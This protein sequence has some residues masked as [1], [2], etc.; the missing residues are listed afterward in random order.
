MVCL[1]PDAATTPAMLADTLDWVP[2]SVPG[3]A[4]SALRAAGRWDGVAPLPLDDRDVWYRGTVE[5][6]GLV[7]LR[8]EGLA[9]RATLWLGEEEILRSESMFVPEERDAQLVPGMRIAIRFASILKAIEG[10]R[11]RPRWRPRLI[12]PPQLRRI[13]TTLLGHMPGWCPAIHTVGPWGA[14]TATPL[15]RTPRLLASRLDARLDADGCGTLTAQIRLS[16]APTAPP[17]L[18]LDGEEAVFEETD[19]TWIA[20]LALAAPRPWWP[21]T[22]GEPVLYEAALGMDGARYSLGRVGFRRLALDRGAD[23]RDFRLVVNGVPLFCRGAN[24]VGADIAAVAQASDAMDAALAH[25]VGAHCNMLRVPGIATYESGAFYRA[26]DRLGILVWQDCAFANFDY[27][28]DDAFLGLACAEVEAFLDRTAASP[29]LAVLCGGSEIAQQAAM[30]GA[31]EAQRTHPLFDTVIPD[32]VRRLRPDIV[33]AP[34]SPFGAGLPFLPGDGVSHYYGVGAYQRALAD[35]RT[36]Q[37]RFASE[38]LAFSIP[39]DDETIAVTLGCRQTHD[40]RWKAGVPRDPGTPWD[41]EDVRDFYLRSQTGLDPAR[42]RYEDPDAYLDRSRAMLA[43]LYEGVI[44]EWRRPGSTNAGALVWLFQDVR[45]GAGWGLLDSEGRPKSSWYGLRRACAPI[46]LSMTDEGLNG[47]FLHL[48][49]DTAESIEATLSFRALYQ[50]HVPVAQATRDIVLPPRSAQTIRSADLLTRFFDVTYAYRF[51]PAAH[52]VS[53]AT[54]FGRH[55]TALSEAIHLVPGRILSPV[56][57]DFEVEPYRSPSGW[58]LRLRANRFAQSIRIHDRALRAEDAWFS[59][60]PDRD[61]HVALAGDESHAPKGEI[62][63]LNAL[64]PWSY[65]A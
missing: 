58:M 19:G 54:L 33:H 65:A 12:A 4:A 41:F 2:A 13:R 48:I 60:A 57:I 44:D 43:D 10:V 17:R 30:L 36:A 49:N 24:W 6:E 7:R 1:P 3:T 25:A 31:A 50:G 46:R 55:G 62:V 32:A 27:P 47:L 18:M 9:T 26:C 53:I 39:P 21:H 22:H 28:D 37:V 34:Q 51:G 52:D 20:R 40:P 38:C 29:S 16:A 8:C 14:I 63:A 35:A 59:M 23:G 45:P 15:D 64:R 61:Y 56:A 5:G 11:D 42:L